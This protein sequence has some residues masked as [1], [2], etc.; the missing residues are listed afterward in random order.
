MQTA[1]ESCEPLQVTVGDSAEDP[2]V[3]LTLG[4]RMPHGSFNEQRTAELTKGTNT[5]T[6]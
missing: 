3:L 1:Q 5:M 6:R 4:T 2:R